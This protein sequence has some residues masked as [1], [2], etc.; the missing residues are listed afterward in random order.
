MKGIEAIRL[1]LIADNVETI[2]LTGN[3]KY[4]KKV[5]NI[6]SLG[7]SGL[8]ISAIEL[9]S[10]DWEIKVVTGGKTEWWK[11]LD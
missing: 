7:Q 11:S 4:R 10:E 9:K 2:Q 5:I 8:H 3:G 1:M 6:K